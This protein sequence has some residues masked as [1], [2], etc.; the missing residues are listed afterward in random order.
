MENHSYA[1]VIGNPSAP[2]LN[3]LAKHGANLTSMY[4]LTHPSQPNYVALFSGS[5]HGVT[6]DVCPQTLTGDNIGHQL[7]ARGLS[8]GAYSEGLPAVGSE[9]CNAGRYARRHAP[10]TNFAN[11][12][13][14][15][16]MPF[17][18]FP[19]DF[20]RLPALSFVVPDVQDDMHDGTVADGDAWLRSHVQPYAAWAATHDSQLVVTWDE[21][22]KSADN[23]IPTIIVGAGIEARTIAT[24]LTLYSLL[25]YLEDRFGLVHLA[26][27][28][29]AAP[30]PLAT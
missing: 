22:D 12:H 30:L 14:T 23:H 4:A 5:T 9:V 21:D 10:W 18:Q 7:I 11:L 24:R 20:N 13:G 2:Y 1:D 8:F 19:T 26:N 3:A 25:R 15:V 27:A 6:D 17:T 28:A 16:S 29:T